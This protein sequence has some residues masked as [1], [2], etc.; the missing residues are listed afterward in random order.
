MDDREIV[1]LFLLRDEAAL[2]EA[3]L[4]YGARLRRLAFNI[5][6]DELTAEECEADAY[7]DAWNSIPPH[8]PY[9]HLFA[10]LGRLVRCRAID[11]L[12]RDKAQKRSAELVELTCEMEQLLPSSAGVEAEAEANELAR[13]I[14]SF[15]GGLPE[16]KRDIFVRRYWFMDTV[17]EIARMTGRGESAVK[18][19]LM[20][21]RGQ[22]KKYLSQNGINV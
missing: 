12:S 4:Q 22:L 15:L 1:R 17:P 9:E 16:H 5:V 18:M 7:L 19:T 20:R 21:L 2:S 13:L 14:N 10:Y 11:R 8:E 6:R 3:K